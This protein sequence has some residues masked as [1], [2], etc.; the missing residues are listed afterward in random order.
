[1]AHLPL[2]V[3]I[4]FRLPST[5]VI[6][7][8]RLV[9]YAQ[10]QTVKHTCDIRYPPKE[11]VCHKFSVVMSPERIRAQ[12]TRAVAIRAVAIRAS[13]NMQRAKLQKY[14]DAH[15]KEEN[16]QRGKSA[17]CNEYS[18]K[19]HNGQKMNTQSCRA[20]MIWCTKNT[21]YDDDDHAQNAEC[22]DNDFPPLWRQQNN[23]QM[24]WSSVQLYTLMDVS[25]SSTKSRKTTTSSFF[26]VL[27][28]FLGTYRVSSGLSN[29]VCALCIFLGVYRV[30]SNLFKLDTTY[31]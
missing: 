31:R 1:M 23:H 11:D 17:R 29:F 30:S 14:K 27:R 19:A 2:S 25:I 22:E 12:S 24:R 20:Q 9:Q 21:E 18:C 16:P 8:S 7:S 15:L 10:W 3:K 28:I 13:A 26:C 6:T 4:F 5:S